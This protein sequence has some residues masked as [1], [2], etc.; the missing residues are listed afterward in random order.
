MKLSIATS[1]DL[2][3]ILN[4]IIDAQTYLASQ[5]VDQWQDGYPDESLI[6]EDISNNESYIV[7]SKNNK[8][9]GTAMFAIK[10]EPTYS[11][12]DGNWLTEKGAKYGVIHRM[13]VSSSYRGIGVA[14]FIFNDCEFALKKSNIASLRIDT[15]ENNLGMQ[16]LVKRLG[17]IYCGVIY[18]P[19]GNKRLAFEKKL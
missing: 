9:V 11:N 15:H 12:I 18:L 6:L 5:G 8:L 4:I 7:K 19:N 13:A 1:T 14:K 3:S 17:Y 16:S 2:S 10:P